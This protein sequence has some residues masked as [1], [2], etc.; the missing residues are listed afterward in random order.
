MPFHTDF[1]NAYGTA[2]SNLS[3]GWIFRCDDGCYASTCKRDTWTSGSVLAIY[4]PHKSMQMHLSEFD[5]DALHAT[6]FFKRKDGKAVSKDQ[7][8]KALQAART[9]EDLLMEDFRDIL[10]LSDGMWTHKIDKNEFAQLA[11]IVKPLELRDDGSISFCFAIRKPGEGGECCGIPW[12]P[13]KLKT[14]LAHDSL[15]YCEIKEDGTLDEEF[16]AKLKVKL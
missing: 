8:K 15:A 10:A 2:L 7:F 9:P 13:R 12:S 11:Q 14:W 1:A 6:V 3:E 4:Q 5:Y 16:K